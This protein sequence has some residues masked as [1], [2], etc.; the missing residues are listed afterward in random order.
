[1]L[2]NL[3]LELPSNIGALGDSVQKIALS[4]HNLRGVIPA[5]IGMCTA[6]RE[7]WLVNNHITGKLPASMKGLGNL[8]MLYLTFNPELEPAQ[9]CLGIKASTQEFLRTLGCTTVK[10]P[11]SSKRW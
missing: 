1:M 9:V 2:G 6:L 4:H 5:E 3:G 7:L 10:R 11:G 8:E